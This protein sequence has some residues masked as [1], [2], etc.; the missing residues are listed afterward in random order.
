MPTSRRST[1]ARSN[2]GRPSSGAGSQ[3]RKRTDANERRAPARPRGEN[4][5]QRAARGETP[6][7][8]RGRSS[9]QSSGT[10]SRRAERPNAADSPGRRD[11][12][13]VARKGAQSVKQA[14][15]G[16]SSSRE[17]ER[18]EKPP[19]RGE[20]DR[21]ERNDG[22]AKRRSKATT[23]EPFVLPPDAV[24]EIEERAGRRASRLVRN[25]REASKAYAAERWGDTRKSLRPLLQEIPD[26]PVVIEL[27]GMLLYRTGKWKP[28]YDALAA[29]HE[30]TQSF[31]LYPAMMD[32]QRA[33]GKPKQ[34][35]K[36]WDELRQASPSGEVMA[37]GRIVMASTLAEQDRVTD[38]IRLLEKTP[39]GSGKPKLYHLRSW[40][41]LADMYERS[42]DVGKALRLF[43]KV[44]S[45][46]PELADVLDRI[47]AL[48]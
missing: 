9:S 30:L 46:D 43:E 28:A 1:G 21:W 32:A 7:G 16:R 31:D 12:G 11:W 23:S 27:N 15:P 35:E 17:A 4:P 24:R 36:L 25:L 14:G 26:A 48:N 18:I 8:R 19:V 22:G 37:E 42:G 41:A 34:V 44:A 6:L 40:Y 29:A 10:Q 33:L 5:Y 3:G 47:E 20:A 39:R 2:G 38:A 13:S 45:H